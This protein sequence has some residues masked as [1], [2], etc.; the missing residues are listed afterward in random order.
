MA[1][2]PSQ[3][4]YYIQ[5]PQVLFHSSTWTARESPFAANFW[6]GRVWTLGEGVAL[7]K[8]TLFVMWVFE[9]SDVLAMDPSADGASERHP[10]VSAFGASAALQ[11]NVQVKVR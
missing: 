8:F 9:C 6:E 10:V 7:P 4:G 2:S 11:Q 3:R 5:P 1:K